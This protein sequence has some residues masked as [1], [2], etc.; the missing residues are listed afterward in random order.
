MRMPLAVPRLSFNVVYQ[1]AFYASASMLTKKLESGS[2]IHI[3][4]VELQGSK[5]AEMSRAKNKTQCLFLVRYF[6]SLRLTR[7][8]WSRY[9]DFE[10]EEQNSSKTQRRILSSLRGSL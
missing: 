8:L 1:T 6:V 4:A 10:M 7:G 9:R 5:I 2:T 3:A